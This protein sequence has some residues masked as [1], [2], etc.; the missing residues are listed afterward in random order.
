MEDF[1]FDIGGIL[2]E[3]EAKKL[4]EEQP[5]ETEET[6]EPETEQTNTPAEE[7]TEETHDP[8]E[9]VG[10]EEDEIEDD[11][12]VQ[13]GSGSSPNFYSSIAKAL[14]NDGVLPD[15]ED[16]ELDACNTPEAFAELFQKAIRSGQDERTQRVN[17][18]LD[19][20]ANPTEVQKMESTIDWLNEIDE[21]RLTAEGDEGDELRKQLIYNDLINRGYEHDKAMKILAKS[22]KDT[23]EVEDARDALEALKKH[24]NKK[25]QDYQDDVR[26]R[27]EA[28]KAEQKKTAD[29]FKK[30]I[31][32]D[33]LKLGDNALDKN[34][35][36][37]VYDAVMKP[38]YKDPETKRYLTQVQK[39]QK[40]NP[41]EFLKQLGMWFVLTDGG[42]NVTGFT[43]K[44][45]QAEKNK[46]IRELANKINSSN[47]SED[48]TVRYSGGIGND[49]QLL[50][51]G[52]KVGWES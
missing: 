45:V 41:L 29:Q 18:L 40:E 17:D 23:T 5:A 46:N 22:F 10:T 1:S 13:K 11:T 43:K 21:D 48:G 24:F 19:R 28:A 42:K 7:E 37:R 26:K 4:F 38:V 3:E 2:S 39:F 35:C 52:W 14:K 47:L 51:D 8:S 31:L 33:E 20:G 44:Q 9:K 15:F 50:S 25:Y 6:H 32:E 16:S 12:T 36:Q 30:M 27:D 49:E 34:T